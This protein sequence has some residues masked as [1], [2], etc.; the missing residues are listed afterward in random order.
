MILLILGIILFFSVHSIGIFASEWRLQKIDQMGILPWKGL[1]SVIAIAGFLLI[2]V[3]Y[4]KARLAPVPIWFPPL[5]LTHVAALFVLISFVLLI[6]TYVP[7]NHIK[8]KVGHPMI[9]AVKPWAFAHLLSNGM[10]ADIIL[11][12]AF[13]IWAIV[14]HAAFKR[15]DQQYGVTYPE[16]KIANDI[17]VLV[18]AVIFYGVFAMF[19]HQRLIGVAPFS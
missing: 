18:I 1:Y 16:G 19:L 12:G 8:Q 2:I 4:G 10:L 5:W 9:T 17:I 15:R 6:A 7:A 14:G 13:L 3:G 11:F